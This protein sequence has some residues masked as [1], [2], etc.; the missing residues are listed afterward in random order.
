MGW[1]G[2]AGYSWAF[3]ITGG[4]ERRLTLVRQDEFKVFESAAILLYLAQ[5]YDK[6]RK[7]SFDP[8]SD[9]Y[10]EALQWIFFAHGGVGPMQGQ[11][12]H[13][14]RY[15]PEKI[16]YG[17][18]R[19]L[20]ETR[21]LYSVLDARLADREWLAGSGRGT[22]S[23]VDI[24]VWPWVK[25]H[26]WSGVESID[27]FPN[28]KRWVEAVRTRPQVQAGL[29]V[30]TPFNPPKSKEEEE[31]AAAAARAWIVLGTESEKKD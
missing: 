10:N 1:G 7:F 28:L 16:P 21:R 26:T 14:S 29:N 19:Y 11:A 25:G 20:D 13:F 15:A 2:C 22:Y 24:N 27:E 6:E 23:I 5:H 4:M 12:N 31:K 9:E 3:A 8:A 18:K 30:P 17:I